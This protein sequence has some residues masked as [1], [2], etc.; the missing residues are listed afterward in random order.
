MQGY[1][2]H[3]RLAQVAPSRS[4]LTLAVEAMRLQP[5]RAAEVQSQRLQPLEEVIA[6][7]VV[8]EIQSPVAVGLPQ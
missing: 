7:E 3:A 1:C 4:G 6:E 2:L 8:M 5:A